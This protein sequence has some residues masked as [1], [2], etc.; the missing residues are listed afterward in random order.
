MRSIYQE[1]VTYF[2]SQAATAEAL[3]LNQSTVSGWTRR[4]FGMSPKVAVMA[5]KA[6]AG[7]FSKEDL[8]PSFPWKEI[9]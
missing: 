9:I 2:G 1:L 6:T 3:N 5:E 7:K 8:C 4:K